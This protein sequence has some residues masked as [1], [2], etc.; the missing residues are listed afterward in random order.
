M[1]T[2]CER[3]W[4]RG[5]VVGAL[6]MDVQAAFPSVNPRCLTR[7]LREYGVDEDL[8]GWIRDFMSNRTVQ[9]VINGGAGPS[10]RYIGPSSGLSHFPPPVRPLHERTT[11]VHGPAYARGH[12]AVLRGRCYVDGL[13]YIGQGDFPSTEQSSEAGHS[14]G[15][16]LTFFVVKLGTGLEG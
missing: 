3:E 10:R 15:S 6:C 11:P 9:M 7:Q 16:E 1:V 13:R 12:W 4:S 5:R 8:V 14:V 2:I